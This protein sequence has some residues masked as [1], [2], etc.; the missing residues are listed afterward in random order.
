VSIFAAWDQQPYEDLMKKSLG[1]Q[2]GRPNGDAFFHRYANA[3]NSLPPTWEQIRGTEP[4]L[5]DHGPRHIQNVLEN[6]RRLLPSD[7][8]LTGIDLYCLGSRPC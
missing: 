1:D 6:A 2:L 7:G 4:F 5:T 3:R 8:R